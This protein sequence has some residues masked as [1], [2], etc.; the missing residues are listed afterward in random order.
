MVCF[1]EEGFAYPCVFLKPHCPGADVWAVASSLLSLLVSQSA[2]APF[3]VTVV[4]A[5]I[6]AHF[7]LIE[8]PVCDHLGVGKVYFLSW[9]WLL[10]QSFEFR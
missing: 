4:T 5:F 1:M 8:Q 6:Y 2:N 7:I 3:L 10:S 9:S